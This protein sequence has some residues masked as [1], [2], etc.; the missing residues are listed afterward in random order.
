MAAAVLSAI[1]AVVVT[2][3]IGAK[4]KEE[5][6]VADPYEEGL[7]HD[8]ERR[9]RERL[10]WEVRTEPPVVTASGVELAFAVLDR[11]GKPVDGASVVVSAGRRETSRGVR[12]LD[13]RPL[14]GGRY[15]VEL[16][17]ED[18]ARLLRFDVRRGADRVRIER[19]LELAAEGAGAPACDLGTSA[20]RA[21]LPS[22]GEVT[23]ELVPRPLATMR[24]LGVIARLP[25]GAEDAEVSVRFEMKGMEMGPNT[26]RL[27]AQGGGAWAGKAVLVRCPSGRRDWAAVVTVARPGSPPESAR[28]DLTVTE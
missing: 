11:A 26:A 8:A 10:G 12:L 23:L 6:I 14:G 21:P 3:W 1:G 2:I 19:T 28:F 16:P 25:L 7:R 22:G 5:K 27:S 9:D 24:E 17:R 20:C 18:G 4:V 15:A 13:A